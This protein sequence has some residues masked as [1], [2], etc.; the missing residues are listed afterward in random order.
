MNPT[1]KGTVIATAG[2]AAA[3]GAAATTAAALR[4]H[5]GV[6]RRGDLQ[7]AAAGLQ[8]EI[9]RVQ[10][11]QEEARTHAEQLEKDIEQMMQSLSEQNE[12][13]A[14]ELRS[15]M[16]R[17]LHEA[18]TLFQE[19]DESGRTYDPFDNVVH[20]L[21]N[22]NE[23]HEKLCQAVYQLAMLKMDDNADDNAHATIATAILNQCVR[24]VLKGY[25]ANTTCTSKDGREI[26]DKDKVV[27]VLDA[28]RAELIESGGGHQETHSTGV[29]GAQ[30]LEAIRSVE[31][32]SQ[33]SSTI[34]AL[35]SVFANGIVE[36]NPSITPMNVRRA[37]VRVV[38]WYTNAWQY[39]A[40]ISY[41]GRDLPTKRCLKELKAFVDI[42]SG[43]TPHDTGGVCRNLKE[44]LGVVYEKKLLA[45]KTV[46]AAVATTETSAQALALH[47][48]RAIEFLAHIS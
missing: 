27:S 24:Q 42:M 17:A 40:N 33:H 2:T 14:A 38:P 16:D 19:T 3:L 10:G 4:A 43:G 47:L 1:K 5:K 32:A 25:K 7:R 8:G 45:P 37:I 12:T 22:H 29:P 44:D 28:L 9:E 34:S 11:D 46:E 6:T 26:G 13:N 39:L 36:L 20:T 35:A 41:T 23:A 48:P 31:S 30:D 15:I 21:V 18:V